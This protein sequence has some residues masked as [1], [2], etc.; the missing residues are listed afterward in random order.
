M[1][2]YLK[3][4]PNTLLFILLLL[5]S[6]LNI[7]SATSSELIPDEAY[8][9]V[10]AQNLEWGY[11]DHPPFFALLTKIGVDIAGDSELGVR[12][13]SIVLQPL[14]IYLFWTIVRRGN[15]DYRSAIRYFLICFSLPMFHVYGFVMT[16]DV[17]LLLATVLTVFAYNKFSSN[18]WPRFGNRGQIIDRYYLISTLLLALGFVMMAYAKYQGVLVVFAMIIAQPRL[19]L[20]WRFYL[21]GVIALI[22]YIPHLKW[23]YSHDFVSFNYHLVERSKHFKFSYLLDYIVNYFV[24]YNPLLTIPFVI[25]LFKQNPYRFPPLERFLRVLAIVTLVFFLY[26]TTKGHVQPQWMLSMLLPMAY[27][28]TRRGNTSPSARRYINVATISVG[29][30]MLTI[31]ILIISAGDILPSALKLYGKEIGINRAEWTIKDVKE[32]SNKKPVEAFITAG[33]YSTAALMSFYSEMPSYAAPS[34]YYRSSHYQFLDIDTELYGKSVAVEINDLVYSTVD[35]DS[36]TKLYK[37]VNIPS[38]GTILYDVV[39]HYIPTRDVEITPQSFPEKLLTK[40]DLA[41]TLKVKNPYNFDI[42]LGGSEGFVMVMHI[43]DSRGKL[44][45]I[46]LPVRNKKL[47][48][49]SEVIIS[50]GMIIPEDFATSDYTMGIMLQRYPFASWYNSKVYEVLVINPKMSRI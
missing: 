25:T 17:P 18:P 7:I 16:P 35:R 41:L 13:L 24:V 6:I 22:L 32:Y 29:A 20:N 11:F 44:F 3:Q 37:S 46:N 42:P 31:H 5:W 47:I 45:E 14:Y 27:F 12:L 28:Y 23:Q 2:K 15:G 33:K 34:V 8:Y 50:T 30:I 10:L 38:I 9:W 48:A 1:L 21:A 39:E 40:Q 36:L 19:L 26:S 49:D 43:R 4:N